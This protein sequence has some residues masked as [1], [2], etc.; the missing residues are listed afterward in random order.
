MA[1]VRRRSIVGDGMKKRS[2]IESS[3]ERE[4]EIETDERE[5]KRNTYQIKEEEEGLSLTVVGGLFST[6]VGGSVVRGVDGH[7]SL[8]DTWWGEWRSR[9]EKRSSKQLEEE[10]VCTSEQ[11]KQT[12]V[13]SN[14]GA[15]LGEKVQNGVLRSTYVDVVRVH[16]TAH[17][18]GETIKDN[19]R[20]GKRI[21]V[22]KWDG[23]YTDSKWLDSCAV[24]VL[25]SFS[26]VPF[27]RMAL[28]NRNVVSSSYYFGDK[29]VLWAFE[30]I[31]DRVV[32]IRNRFLWEVGEPLL[33]EDDTLK[34]K[35]LDRG[36]VLVLLPPSLAC[37]DLIKVITANMS[38]SISFD[39]V[40]STVDLGWISVILGL[41]KGVNGTVGVLEAGLEKL[42]RRADVSVE[43]TKICDKLKEVEVGGL[44]LTNLVMREEND[45]LPL[46]SGF[47]TSING[48]R[49]LLNKGVHS[50][51]K[52][53]EPEFIRETSNPMNGEDNSL[54]NTKGLNG[55]NRHSEGVKDKADL[56]LSKSLKVSK[57]ISSSLKR[58]GMK[59][60][61]EVATNCSVKK[62]AGRVRK[63]ERRSVEDEM[64]KVIDRGIEL[65]HI[66]M[67]M[68]GEGRRV[69]ISKSR[70]Q[71][72]G[73][74]LSI[75]VAKVIEMGVTLGLDFN[76]NEGFDIQTTAAKKKFE[77]QINNE[78]LRPTAKKKAKNWVDDERLDP[79][80]IR[81][82]G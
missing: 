11:R 26:D 72:D 22:V 24:G 29:N 77:N 64:A 30:S 57:G 14:G 37:P 28:E 52:S 78:R 56:I 12:K 50:E 17:A 49:I 58:H 18:S 35:R 43:G 16:S 45:G 27:C 47:N 80:D 8:Q 20:N 6:T 75:E 54:A 39:E 38:C 46:N 33:V 69:V 59:T 36:R 74:S 79:N 2:L 23:E 81:E 51:P 60:R 40:K 5:R 10:V 34:R 15:K 70:N 82:E 65:G 25:K 48:D 62:V 19:C 1:T 44:R 73:W 4:S 71:E 21:E 55:D 76:N 32:F 7:G 31:N 9:E 63:N 3:K 13:L 67:D 41:D 66:N 68:A 61:S 53:T 42:K